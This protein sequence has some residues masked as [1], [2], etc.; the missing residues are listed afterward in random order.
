MNFNFRALVIQWAC[1]STT[2]SLAYIG[3]PGPLE[4]HLRNRFSSAESYLLPD[5]RK[6]IRRPIG[7]DLSLTGVSPRARG[8]LGRI[9]QQLFQRVERFLHLYKLSSDLIAGRLR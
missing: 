5:C 2:H 3:K 6:P 8:L 4:F 1:D 9:S 7:N